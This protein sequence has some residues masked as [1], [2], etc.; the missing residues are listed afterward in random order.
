[1]ITKTATTITNKNND[2]SKQQRS[3]KTAAIRANNNDYCKLRRPQE[4]GTTTAN[5]SDHCKPLRQQHTAMTRG[6]TDARSLIWPS[7]FELGFKIL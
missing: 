3:L 4:T 2:Q 7:K 5:S 1:M 6:Q